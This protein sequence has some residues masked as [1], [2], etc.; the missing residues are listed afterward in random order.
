MNHFDKDWIS[1]CNNS[2]SNA[3]PEK[4]KAQKKLYN[5]WQHLL[6]QKTISQSDINDYKKDVDKFMSTVA[7]KKFYKQTNIE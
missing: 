6:H 3:N 2:D 4:C 5:K 1:A 7:G